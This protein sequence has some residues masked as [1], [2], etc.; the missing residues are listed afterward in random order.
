M[1]EEKKVLPPTR[2][3]RLVPGDVVQHFKR[4]LVGYKETQYLYKILSFAEHTETGEKLVI[5]QALYP[6]FGVW[7]RPWGMFM[8]PVDKN[9]YP[10]SHQLFRFELWE[11]K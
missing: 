7:A 3:Y 4:E 1:E 5:Y 10:N 8:G 6:P 9:K 11:G 2:E